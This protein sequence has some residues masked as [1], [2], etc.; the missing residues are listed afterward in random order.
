MFLLT[1][2][3]LR[4]IVVDFDMNFFECFTFPDPEDFDQVM[5]HFALH[6]W[7]WTIKTLPRNTG[8]IECPFNTSC[9]GLHK[10]GYIKNIYKV[11]I[12]LSDRIIQSSK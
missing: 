6:V 4:S 5:E 12:N 1:Q 9:K 2:Q 8:R 11:T 3:Q 7:R 10:R